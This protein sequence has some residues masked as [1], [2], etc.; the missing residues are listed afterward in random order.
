MKEKYITWRI[1]IAALLTIV[2]IIFS[3]F[4]LL[5]N[6]AFAS[7][8]LALVSFLYDQDL[9]IQ[10]KL[11]HTEDNSLQMSND[12]KKHLQVIRLYKT[13]KT[14]DEYVINRLNLIRSVKNTSFNLPK[15]HEEADENFNETREVIDAP[16]VVKEFIAREGLKWRDIGDNIAIERFKRWHE[17]CDEESKKSEVGSYKSSIINN[18]NAVPYPNFLIIKYKDDKEE[19]LFN[20]DHRSSLNPT[21]LA[22]RE[23]E[24]V[25]FYNAQFK[26]LSDA[27]SD[28]S[29][30]LD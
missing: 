4:P 13:A 20:W 7:F 19:V 29:D 30:D 22:S 16:V 9:K 28:S 8:L 21:V 26:L 24:L 25:R 23:E 3:F 5:S 11:E 15:S 1:G 27:A 12:V 17:L 14:F 10:R 2:S 6:Y 18:Y